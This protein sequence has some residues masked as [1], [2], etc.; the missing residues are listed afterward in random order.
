MG[1]YLLNP[2]KSFREIRDNYI[3]YIKTAFAS[4]FKD[5]ADCFEEQREHLLL[6]DQVLSRTPWI[7]PLPTYPNKIRNGEKISI[8]DMTSEDLIGMNDRAQALFKEFIATGLMSY[9]L[10]KHQYD[11]LRQGLQGK[12]CVITSG[13]GSGK[14]ESF[15]LPLFADIIK[16]AE[17]WPDRSSQPYPLNA[18]W[19]NRI[20]QNNL[21]DF[22]SHNEGR[23]SPQALQRPI[24]TRPAAIRAIVIYPMNALVEDQMT[25]LREALD[26]DE[27]QQ[28]MDEK[29]GGNRIF[30][31]RYNSTTPVSGQFK[32]SDDHDVETRLKTIRL[33]KLR[34]L[35][36]I[37]K[38]IEKQSNAINEWINETDIT[39]SEREWRKSMKYTFQRLSGAEGR[40][41][42]EMRSRFDMQQTPPDILITNYSML[43]I[44]LMRTAESPM[45]N[46][47]RDWLAGEQNKEN[48]TRVFHL[49]I[50][51]L[52]LNRGTSGT[53]IAYLLRVLINRLGLS[54]NSKQ[55][56]ILASSASLEGSDPKSLHYLNDFFNREFTA[57]NLIPGNRIEVEQSYTSPLPIEPFCRV[58]DYYNNNP[59]CFD[60]LRASHTQTEETEKTLELLEGVYEDLSNI[61]GFVSGKTSTQD[62][63][64]DLLLSDELALTQRMY[65]IFD[66]GE[67]G[68]NR[69]IPLSFAEGDNN[70]LNKYF[71][72]LFKDSRSQEKAAE[73]LIILRGLFDIFGKP[74]EHDSRM[75]IPRLRFHFFFKNIG[76]LW[77]TL[78]RPKWDIG[79]PV[80]KLHA[81]PT[82]IDETCN[83]HRILELLYCEECGSLYYGGRRHVEDFNGVSQTYILPT[84]S[85]I[86]SLPEQST[87]VIVDKRKYFE[88]AI[89][90]PIDKESNDYEVNNI[91]QIVND[92]SRVHLQ[93]RTNFG[94]NASYV[95][96]QWKRAQLN[97]LSGEVIL[98][99]NDFVNDSDDFIDG[100]FYI[101]N[102]T[103]DQ[104]RESPALPG[105]CP[106]CG[107][108]HYRAKHRLSPI[109]GFR[110]GFQ[111]TTQTFA[112]E[113][114]YQ[115]PTLNKPKLVTFSDSR[116]DAASV[117]NGIEREQ[118]IDLL[119]DVFIDLCFER[120]QKYSEE[121]AEN[122]AKKTDLEGKLE[123]LKNFPDLADMAEDY[124]GQITSISTK[125]EQLSL[126]SH[127]IKLSELL[128]SEK[129]F[130]S[131]LYTRLF[132]LGVNPAG[133][134]WEN[135]V[136]YNG[137]FS[138]PWY[139]LYK[140]SSSAGETIM[141]DFKRN[142]KEVIEKNLSRIFF[143]RLVYSIESSGVGYITVDPNKAQIDD[144]RIHYH[145]VTVGAEQFH[146]IVSTT[147]RLLGEKYR[148]QPS[149]YDIN[150]TTTSYRNAPKYIKSY[151]AK[152]SERFCVA[153]NDLGQAVFDFLHNLGH[154]NLIVN[155]SNI[156]VR[157][158]DKSSFAYICPVCKR[159]HL[160]KSAGICSGCLGELKDSDAIPISDLQQDNYLLLNKNLGRRP[161]R[162]HC[163]ELTGQTDNQAE[164]QRF[165]KDF[166]IPDVHDDK[167][168]I[169]KVKSI[170][171]L[172]VTTTMEVG[173]D[174]GALQAVM[175]ANMPPQRYNYQQRV[176]R[177]GRRGQSYSMILTL[178]RGRSHDEHYFHNPH[179]ITGDQPPTPFLSM[180]SSDIVQR[181]FNKEVLYNAFHSL[182]H[183]YGQLDGSTH[184][185]FGLKENWHI[186]AN[187]IKSWLNNPSN[188][189]TITTIASVLTTS[190]DYLV[191]WATDERGLFNAIDLALHNSQIASDDIAETLAEA[192]LLPMY[193]MP[194][195]VRELYTRLDKVNQTVSSVNR[196]IEIAIT[197]FAPGSQV[198]KDKK[199]VTS[200]GF[201]SPSLSF[202]NV[203]GISSIR[204]I[205]HDGIFSLKA[206]LHKCENPACTFFETI[207]EGETGH[208]SCP[209]CGASLTNINLRTP[210]AFVTDM[211]PGD[212]RATDRGVFVIRKGIVAEERSSDTQK[213]NISR[214]EITLAKK[215][216]TWRISSSDITG[217]RCRVRY[218]QH[219]EWI[220]NSSDQWLVSDI[221]MENSI[222]RLV[223]EQDLTINRGDGKFLTKITPYADND[224]PEETIRLAAQKVTN[225]I[226]LHP[227]NSVLGIQLNPLIYDSEHGHLHFAGQGV[228]AAYFSLAFIL[229]RA[230]ASKLDV[231]PR[232]V[233]VVDLSIYQDEFGQVTLAD[234]QVNGS[235]FVVDF[236]NNFEE[237]KHRILDGEDDFFDK[238]LSNRHAATCESTCYECLSNYNNMP[239]HG[240]LDWRLGIS[241]FRIMVDENYK[242]GLDGNF[243]Y[244]ELLGWAESAK[245]LLE[246]FNKSMYF[247]LCETGVAN[248][249]PYLKTNEG[250]YI[251]V[252]HPLWEVKTPG[253]HRPNGGADYSSKNNPLLVKACRRVL[254]IPIEDVITIDTFNL[255]R[256]MGTCFSYINRP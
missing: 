132:D 110:A 44:M 35:R 43:A 253:A 171:I 87:Q 146:E 124:Q 139:T 138:Y 237:Y 134:D 88:Y 20:N 225:V 97:V 47:T 150:N 210:N 103:N 229:Q 5:K 67:L 46:L 196:D 129:L 15:L 219:N 216:W 82:L 144:T 230:I 194:T 76:G 61:F 220:N 164:R 14:T 231:D 224:F 38:D 186:Y 33:N 234:E 152:C 68:Q 63:L 232:E 236:F 200:I 27:I 77:A 117:A 198:T 174:I 215:D 193:G 252:V 107:V 233:E 42:S 226:K 154:Q 155:I 37:L 21:L 89:F 106:F 32:R 98:D 135:Q 36:D 240:L 160:H 151:I 143:G 221:P 30:F 136:Y 206:I 256:R 4:R 26:S 222:L 208:S 49:V 80:G 170:D 45:I 112:R 137:Q 243:E 75:T 228:R 199:V 214:G 255:T 177:G 48:P 123:R 159:V 202:I 242:V 102:L 131:E 212:N 203:G 197:S 81:N 72:H 57:E 213:L 141:A 148:Y 78:E 31:G 62:K 16:E 247:G 161:I 175:L 53:E 211:T 58:A 113:L 64:L 73:G 254:H 90:W 59:N 18:W 179:Q 142:A 91:P 40:I 118:F 201:S 85:S 162:I 147:M 54:P 192:G 120:F 66:C 180:D 41:S 173:V 83:N 185:E 241:L 23:L 51:E 244:P 10:Y 168:I 122:K 158:S 22:D 248:G 251:F 181:L 39:E 28:F 183:I 133:C 70:K 9:P 50:D 191:E 176:G 11:M 84:S 25:R 128:S 167:E 126:Q 65:D 249:L 74:F 6:Q 207:A 105:H 104:E 7:E 79:K 92:G 182:T 205:S 169:K 163:E 187:Q 108:D 93:H 13:T 195:R 52:H 111:K 12:D 178:C 119:R 56:R 101:A 95:S 109:R 55:L 149:P 218:K 114:F 96:C 204:S 239:Y 130:E 121:I 127:Y 60:V 153:E 209:V 116:E 100:Y 29:L 189:N 223:A 1:Q 238:M 245:Q 8:Q 34:N 184:G 17:T 140:S 3:T 94:Q 86:E 69:A 19:N 24:C 99:S 125:I 250:K 115:L 190:K 217:R 172:S 246:D 166:I 156:Y 235:G 71:C 157:T 145:I 165:F 227:S 188:L 2:I